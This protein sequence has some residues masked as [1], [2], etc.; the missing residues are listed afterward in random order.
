MAAG[1]TNERI[2]V[3]IEVPSNEVSPLLHCV[4]AIA[5]GRFLPSVEGGS[6][7]AVYASDVPVAVVHLDRNH[8]PKL[9]PTNVSI[10]TLSVLELRFA[11]HQ[12][13]DPAELLA[14]VARHFF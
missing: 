5:E 7:W 2:Q 3:P 10:N 11:Y 6:T 14:Q 12:S 1:D 9:T 4:R 13:A 8:V